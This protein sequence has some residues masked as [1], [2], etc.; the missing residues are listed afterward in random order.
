[1]LISTSL[2]F[3]TLRIALCSAT[4]SAWKTV[5]KGSSWSVEYQVSAPSHH[6]VRAAPAFYSACVGIDLRPD[7]CETVH[8]LGVKVLDALISGTC[9]G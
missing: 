6:S 3:F 9:A 4:I 1:M 7:Y 8:C 5:Q 2:P